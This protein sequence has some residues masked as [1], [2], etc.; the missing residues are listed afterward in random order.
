MYMRKCKS[1]DPRYEFRTLRLG[2]HEWRCT[3]CG[4][5]FRWRKGA[6]WDGS[7]LCEDE[8]H[9]HGML[10]PPCAGFMNI[11]EPTF[12]RVQRRQEGKMKSRST[13]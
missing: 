12:V 1:T 7:L 2:K 3:S 9:C 4:D 6:R 11:E 5:G 13:T 8:G 10:C